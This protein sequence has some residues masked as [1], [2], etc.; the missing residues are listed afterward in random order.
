MKHAVGIRFLAAI[1]LLGAESRVD[2]ACAADG[3]PALSF[4]EIFSLVSSNLPSANATELSRAAALGFVNQLQ[5]QVQLISPDD[6]NPVKVAATKGTVVENA[7]AVIR[8]PALDGPVAAEFRQAFQGLGS[9]NKLKGVVLDLRFCTGRDYKAATAIADQFLST[10]QPLFTAGG[11]NI[12]STV[13]SDAITLPIALLV[14]Q[15]TSG[16]SELLAALLRHTAGAVVI[17]SRTAGGARIFQDY[18]LSTGQK[19]RI[20]KADLELPNGQS[21]SAKGITPDITIQVPPDEERAFMEDPY[22]SLAQA[23]G[24][25]SKSGGTNAA[26]SA[27]I[28]TNRAMRRNFNEAELVRRHRE[29]LDMQGLTARIEDDRATLGD[30]ALGRAIDF[31]KGLAVVQQFGKGL[32]Q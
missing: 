30:P 10:A 14:N 18:T 20:A 5:P 11:T 13:K 32:K 23:Y 24:R 27:V 28:A 8:L 2:R 25:N 6:M 7:Y 9:S 4:Q 3:Q 31:L 12:E 29:G 1:A 22:K 17:G 16:A 15:Q 26:T 19:L 21:L